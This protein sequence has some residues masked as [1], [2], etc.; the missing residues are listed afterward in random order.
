M[1]STTSAAVSG[2]ADQP[3][4]VNA[5]YESESFSTMSPRR[6]RPGLSTFDTLFQLRIFEVTYV[7]QR[8]EM[9]C[10]VPLCFQNYFL[11]ALSVLQLP[12]WNRFD[13]LP[14]LVHSCFCIR[15]WYRMRHRN[16]FVYQIVT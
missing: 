15:N 14:F 6:A 12:R 10:S 13:L 16:K 2:D 1:T 8:R 7:H 4:S 11:F 5:A 3:C 9:D